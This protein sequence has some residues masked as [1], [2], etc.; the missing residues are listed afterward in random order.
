MHLLHFCLCSNKIDPFKQ[1]IPDWTFT[2]FFSHDGKEHTISRNTSNQGDIYFDGGKKKL[3][4]AREI[5]LKM[6]VNDE[7]PLSFQSLLSCV[8]RRYR[9]CYNKYNQSS[10]YPDDYT[11]LLHNGFL[12]GL[13]TELIINKK[14]LR[15]EQDNLKKTE[16]RLKRILF[17]KSIILVAVMHNS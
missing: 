1:K 9:S 16:N 3:T 11:A 8:A 7:I 4:E 14:K 2:L 5:L 6:I 12:L 13:N 10:S 15:T 17:S